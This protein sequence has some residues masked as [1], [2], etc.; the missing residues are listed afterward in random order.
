M[1]EIKFRAWDKEKKMLRKV[2]RI[3]FSTK[4]IEVEPVTLEMLDMYEPVLRTGH[5]EI[6]QCT[7]LKDTNGI[8][9]YEGDIVQYFRNELA[10]IVF[11][12]GGVDIRGLSSMEREPLQSRMGFMK[13]LG[14]I[15]E[16]PE[17][18]EREV[19]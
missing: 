12:N 3:S 5:Y 1:R 15:Y 17:L 9:I 10:V 11:Q 6:M 2:T 16:N 18:L 4:Y 14:N 8:E 7:N 13:V 19:G